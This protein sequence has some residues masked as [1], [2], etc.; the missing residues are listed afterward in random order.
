MVFLVISMML[1]TKFILRWAIILIIVFMYYMAL[2]AG[3][4]EFDIFT[5]NEALSAGVMTLDEYRKSVDSIVL[6]TDDVVNISIFAF[7][8]ALVLSLIAF[9]KIR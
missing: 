1:K 9:R 7:P 3:C 5:Q 2:A 4:Q 8:I 6:A